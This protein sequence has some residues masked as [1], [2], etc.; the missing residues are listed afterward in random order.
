MT[1]DQLTAVLSR[2]RVIL[3]DFDGPICSVF[4][5]YPARTVAADLRRTVETRFGP[6]PAETLA[7]DPLDLLR[8]YAKFCPPD[9]LPFAATELRD[10]E[11]KA[12]ASAEPTPGGHEALIAARDSGRPVAMVSNNAAEAL[13]AYLER[14]NLLDRVD[15]VVGRHIGMDPRLLKPDPYL[16]RRALDGLTVNAAEAVLV[17]D[18]TSDI[19]AAH[20]AGALAIGYANKPGKYEAQTRAGAHAIVNAMTEF[21]DVLV[22]NIGD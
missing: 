22:R 11:V 2:A 18:Q 19:E 1:D 15:L 7:Y 10:L 21:V 6:L 13:T 20:A 4:A 12:V 8:R 17:G 5:G 9:V 3:L 16:L 14:H